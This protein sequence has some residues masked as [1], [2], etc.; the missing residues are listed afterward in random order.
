MCEDCE[1]RGGK[2][3]WR[4]EEIGFR[5]A[6]FLFLSYCGIFTV[7]FTAHVVAAALQRYRSVIIARQNA[8]NSLVERFRCSCC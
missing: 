2:A 6:V 8:S 4:G 5:A 3:E 7:V 1:E